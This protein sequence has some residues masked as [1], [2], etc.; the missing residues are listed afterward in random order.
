MNG[1]AET[2]VEAEDGLELRNGVFGAQR[3][4]EMLELQHTLKRC[5]QTHRRFGTSPGKIL[6]V[7]RPSGA[8]DYILDVQPLS[9]HPGFSETA[10]SAALIIINDPSRPVLIEPAT[11]M[12]AF[13][14]TRMEAKITAGLVEGL[15]SNEL[16]ER[17]G[18]AHS[19]LRTHIK[20]VFEKLNVTQRADLVRTVMAALPAVGHQE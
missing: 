20:H 1:I 17:H 3:D 14:L 4:S 11:L 15:H 8:L 10:G 6:R 16:A 12:H 18:I 5:I 7:A 2:L 19:T 9:D 13:E